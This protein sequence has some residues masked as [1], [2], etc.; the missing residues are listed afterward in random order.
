MVWEMMVAKL[1]RKP[2]CGKTAV[3]EI[4][5]TL[6][7]QVKLFGVKLCAMMSS[8]LVSLT[9]RAAEAAAASIGGRRR[10]GRA[11]TESP[12]ASPCPLGRR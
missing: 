12:P 4:I 11:E 3:R 1:V 6:Q 10:W 2:P 5:R 7:L 8:L 9:G